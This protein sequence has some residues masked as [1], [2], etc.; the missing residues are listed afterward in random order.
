MEEPL[1]ESI[2]LRAVSC[3]GTKP[4]GQNGH[5]DTEAR[6][7]LPELLGLC[8]VESA[9]GTPSW[10]DWSDKSHHKPETPMECT[11]WECFNCPLV[12]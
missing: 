6:R 10:L 3:G 1:L 7:F 9:G 4:G 12:L 11:G 8:T 5:L 2:Q